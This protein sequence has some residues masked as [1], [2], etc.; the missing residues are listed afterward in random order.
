VDDSGAG[1]AL[2]LLAQ[3][4]LLRDHPQSFLFFGGTAFWLETVAGVKMLAM[5]AQPQ[6]PV[7]ARFAVAHSSELAGRVLAF[8]AVDG[9]NVATLR[10]TLPWLCPVPLGLG[11]SAGF[12]DR[13]GLATP[14]HARALQGV[15]AA[16]PG[17]SIDPIFAQQSIREM[18]RTHRGPDDVLADAT[19][20]AFEA[21]WRGRLG[22]DADHLMSTDDVDATAA[23]GFTFFTVDPSASVDDT[24][25]TADGAVLQDCLQ[26]LP[27][28][29]LE[30]SV[31]DLRRR[32]AGAT[33]ELE[34]RQV[35]VDEEALTRAAVKFGR[36]IAHVRRLYLHLLARHV[37]CELEVSVD[38]TESA[39]SHVEHIYIA[40][41][42]SRLGVQF[43]SLAPRFVGRFEKGVEFIGDRDALRADLK[44]HA[45]IARALG[46]YKLSLHSGSD[47]FS[48]YAPAYEATRGLVH[49]KTAG[50]SYLEAL[51]VVA[52]TDPELFR[53]IVGLARARYTRDR[54]T[55]HVSATVE[56]VPV[57]ESIPDH[58][59]PA[60]L[61]DVDARQVL[62][63]TFGTVLDAFGGPLLDCLRANE[64]AYHRTIADHFTRHLVPFAQPYEEPAPAGSI[65]S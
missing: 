41:E 50:T 62:H 47:K 52:A 38:E 2:S 10:D 48:V 23:A 21:G 17:A 6:A 20:G 1:E 25:T 58:A 37:P 27:W 63:V 19:W 39:T 36:A 26:A 53:Q 42:L 32:Y 60:L 64:D 55:Y 5:L 57:P 15:L 65:Q 61:D 12:G 34:D 59:L 11:T 8:C 46:P 49:L 13:L 16:A 29:E 3:T 18:G 35:R 33:I 4:E 51:R 14:G 54:V 28:E 31:S 22:A 40:S 9:R 7:L 30:S 44:V 24:A 45:K 56:A 43:I